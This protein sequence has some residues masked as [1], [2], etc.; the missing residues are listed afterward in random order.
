MSIIFVKTNTSLI[1]V[2]FVMMLHGV[3]LHH[4]ISEPNMQMRAEK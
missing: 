2:L 1:Y 4:K 3:L